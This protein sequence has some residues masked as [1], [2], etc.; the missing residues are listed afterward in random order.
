MIPRLKAIVYYEGQHDVPSM[1]FLRP[2]KNRLENC[3]TP[4]RIFFYA[5]LVVSLTVGRFVRCYPIGSN[6]NIV[7]NSGFPQQLVILKLFE[8]PWMIIEKFPCFFKLYVHKNNL[9]YFYISDFTYNFF[10]FF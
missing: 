9:N 2:V 8:A 10:A 4:C 3:S 1:R 5:V 6:I 7:I